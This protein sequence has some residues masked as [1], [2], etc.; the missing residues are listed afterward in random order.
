MWRMIFRFI[1]VA[2]V[3]AGLAWLADRP[4]TVEIDWLGTT[5]EMPLIAGLFGLLLVM[6]VLGLAWRLLRGL[7]AAPGSVSGFFS[8][9]KRRKGQAALSKGIMA[10]GAGDV[11]SA[12][13]YAQLAARSLPDEPL[14]RLLKAQTAQLRGDRDT[15]KAIYEEMTHHAETEALGLRGLFNLARQDG[16]YDTARDLAD[17]AVRINPQLAWASNAMLVI[18]SAQSDWADA[19]RLIETQKRNG[20]LDARAAARK[21]AVIET[22]RALEMEDGNPDEA[23]EHALAAHKL[24]PGLVPAAVVASRLQ[25]RRGNVRKAMRVI[26]RTWRESP[27]RDLAEAYAHVRPGDSAKDRLKRVR[28]LVSREAGGEEGAIALARASIEAQDWALARSALTPLSSDR[29]S[30]AVCSLMAEIEF[31][32]HSDKGKVREWLARGVNAPRDPAWTA[33][34]YVSETWLPVSPVT[35]ELDAFTWKRPVEG[36]SDR[37]E[38]GAF[39]DSQIA[40]AADAQANTDGSDAAPTV[41]EATAAT[42]AQETERPAPKPDE[43]PSPAAEAK[44]VPETS[45]TAATR[46]AE[47][48]TTTAA[49]PPPDTGKADKAG[50]AGRTD[51]A[52]PPP[53]SDDSSLESDAD[54]PAQPHQP[55]DPGP[56]TGEE[57]ETRTASRW[58]GN[59]ERK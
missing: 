37:R 5:V 15:A 52:T 32:E 42:P 27:H 40:E 8:N 51:E 6:V 23:L 24:S 57:D 7:V 54:R 56:E 36:L 25:A 12:K 29:P 38:A 11:A 4:G 22:A 10:V 20:Q 1:V 50:K 3:A 13:R 58:F 47:P 44:A 9:R 2:L 53:A 49:T 45:R 55:D 28:S 35:G 17:R 48:T 31:G 34:G 19:A 16:E 18:H 46:P 33:D 41:I 59:A 14:A 43:A 26:E 30:V 21:T 39:I